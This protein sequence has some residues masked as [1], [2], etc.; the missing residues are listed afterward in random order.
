MDLLVDHEYG[1]CSIENEIINYLKDL[2]KKLNYLTF[3]LFEA[4]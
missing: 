2:F 1:D 3:E 4:L